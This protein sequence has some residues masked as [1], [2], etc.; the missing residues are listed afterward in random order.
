MRFLDVMKDSLTDSRFVHGRVPIS[1]QLQGDTVR[2]T[3]GKGALFLALFC[4]DEEM[5]AELQGDGMPTSE[6]RRSL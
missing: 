5:E 6:V 1:P 4:C 3:A 2:T